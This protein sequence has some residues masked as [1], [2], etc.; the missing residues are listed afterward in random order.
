MKNL[1]SAMVQLNPEV[2]KTSCQTKNKEPIESGTECT[3][4]GRFSSCTGVGFL[5]GNSTSVAETG[6]TGG[7]SVAAE[8]SN[9]KELVTSALPVGARFTSVGEREKSLAFKQ[10]ILFAYCPFYEKLQFLICCLHMKVPNPGRLHNLLW[11][12]NHPSSTESNIDLNVIPSADLSSIAYQLKLTLD[13]EKNA[14]INAGFFPLMKCCSCKPRRTNVHRCVPEQAHCTGKQDKVDF[15]VVHID[16][17]HDLHGWSFEQN[18]SVS[19]FPIDC[20][21]TI[22]FKIKTH[23]AIEDRL[24]AAEILQSLDDF[25]LPLVVDTMKNE[26]NLNYGG[27]PERMCVVLDGEVKYIGGIGPYDFNIEEMITYLEKIVNC[28]Y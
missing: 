4:G 19:F 24:S 16:E 26:A 13:S 20:L 8:F 17:I 11:L 23:R 3:A 27:L 5:M 12:K 6:A 18:N 2:G 9:R 1:Q 28:S 21:A 10:E 14:A 15:V 7:L 25:S 22:W